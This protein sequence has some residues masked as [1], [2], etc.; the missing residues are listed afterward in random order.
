MANHNPPTN[1]LDKR[2]EQ[3]NR[4]G[5]PKSFDKL[6]EL[7]Q[8]IAHEEARTVG[9]V[10]ADGQVIPGNPIII[11]GHVA[12]V[13]EMMLRQWANSKD[14]RF[15]IAF[16]EYAYGKVPAKQE[17]MNID[18]S[19]LTEE[20]LQMLRDGKDLLDVLKHPGA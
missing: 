12:T 20:Q 15:A 4:K 5:R 17:N 9:K 14:P 6:R 8:S 2:K 3:I 1:G 18:L 16:M 19:T 13:A 10:G 7:A 11:D